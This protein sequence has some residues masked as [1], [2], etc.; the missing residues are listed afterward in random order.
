MTNIHNVSQKVSSDARPVFGLIREFERIDLHA[1]CLQLGCFSNEMVLISAER[2]YFGLSQSSGR[3]DRS[4]LQELVSM[5][6]GAFSREMNE[7][8]DKS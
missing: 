4:T 3:S 1:V 8:S 5:L 7:F 2:I 6:L